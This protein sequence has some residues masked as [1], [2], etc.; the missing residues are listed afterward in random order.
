METYQKVKTQIAQ[1]FSHVTFQAQGHK[2]DVGPGKTYVTS[3]SGYIGEYKPKFDAPKI[4][5]FCARKESKIRGR[6]VSSREIL[7]EWALK[8]D[9][10]A[11]EGTKV[12]KILEDYALFGTFPEEPM[13]GYWEKAEQGKVFLDSLSEKGEIPLLCE[14]NLYSEELQICGQC[15]LLTFDTKT[16]AVNLYDYKTN[17]SDLRAWKG[18]DYFK[19][20]FEK[21]ENTGLNAYII[22]AN[23]YKK[24]V[25]LSGCK[26]AEMFIV[27]LKEKEYEV[28]KV[29][30]VFDDES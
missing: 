2:Y 30:S 17:S 5:G 4:A 12:H 22:Q 27:W 25:E 19:A 29:P 3:V 6:Y 9:T 23:L 7:N 13:R 18:R 20:P 28:I 10:A 24:M 15:D 14:Q 11:A 8:R 26:V 16:S 1:H 21:W